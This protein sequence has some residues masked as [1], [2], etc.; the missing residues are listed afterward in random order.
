MEA[1]NDNS[2][3]LDYYQQQYR[4][5]HNLQERKAH[6]HL[7]IRPAEIFLAVVMKRKTDFP[8]RGI[9]ADIK[10]DSLGKTQQHQLGKTAA[11][12]NE[13]NRRKCEYQKRIAAERA[14]R[15][16]Y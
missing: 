3:H 15:Q 6:Q 9:L 2:A 8:Y 11:A 16:T 13:N 10:A 12:V 14:A 4:H 7:R 5:Y 1:T